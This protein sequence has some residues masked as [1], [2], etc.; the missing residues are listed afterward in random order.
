MR[1]TLGRNV[2]YAAAPGRKV[3]SWPHPS[4]IM[5]ITWHALRVTLHNALQF[6]TVKGWL[7]FDYFNAV[8]G[9]CCQRRLTMFTSSDCERK[10]SLVYWI[11]QVD[12]GQSARY[13]TLRIQPSVWTSHRNSL[14]KYFGPEIRFRDGTLARVLLSEVRF[15]WLTE[16]SIDA[17]PSSDPR[18]LFDVAFAT[19]KCIDPIRSHPLRRPFPRLES[20]LC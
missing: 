19:V 13:F 16:L 6:P 20:L 8:E 14:H 17:H 3:P 1:L 7:R 10:P 11:E 18:L 4:L 15:D 2:N 9:A 12:W 5:S